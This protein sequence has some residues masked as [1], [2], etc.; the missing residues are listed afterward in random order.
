MKAILLIIS[1]LPFL[2]AFNNKTNRNFYGKHFPNGVTS[3]NHI[4]SNKGTWKEMK[5][6]EYKW[7]Y[8]PQWATPNHPFDRNSL[9]RYADGR[10]FTTCR[11]ANGI[12]LWGMHG[13]D[14]INPNA[15]GFA[16]HEHNSIGKNGRVGGR[17][18]TQFWFDDN[19]L[20]RYM[21]EAYERPQPQGLWETNSYL[22][23]RV[24]G[25]DTSHWN[26][27]NSDF[28]D[29][30]A[31]DGLFY[32]SKGDMN[33]ARSK[34]NRI[35]AKS[36]FYYDENNQQFIYRNIHEN[37]HLGLFG[38]LTG[39]LMKQFPQDLEILNHHVSIRSNII[40]FQEKDQDGNL[41][42]WRSDRTQDHSLIN[43]ESVS[44][45]SLALG[46][47]SVFVFEAGKHPLKMD[48]RNYFIRPYNALSAVVS[49]SQ[50]GRMI[51]GSIE[52]EAGSFKI[53]Y[54]LRSPANVQLKFAHV[55]VLQS[56]RILKEMDL[57]KLN[58]RNQW[59]RVSLDFRSTRGNV[60]F[61]LHWFGVYNLDISCVS[62]QRN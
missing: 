60:E 52:M 4:Y 51:L 2:L 26:P 36:G 55:R 10:K 1:F 18:F 6:L 40:Q 25:G 57:T 30:L 46:V 43:T 38:I 22:R 8:Y 3:V 39:F 16:F 21:S 19:W 48:E 50:I 61:E 49:L 33:N 14:E 53:N 32:F 15:G 24:I 45:N 29:T 62:I 37:Y 42:G 41:L 47:G 56:G 59:T 23:W 11:D 54:F 9:I 27:Y 31:L 44:V 13:Q 35:L 12:L 28:Y 20:A 34:W 17:P 7:N 58:E 5:P